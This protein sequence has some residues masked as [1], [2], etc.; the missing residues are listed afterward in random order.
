MPLPQLEAL[1]QFVLRKV[2]QQLAAQTGA[3]AAF[4][5]HSD[6]ISALIKVAC[7]SMENAFEHAYW[8]SSTAEPHSP[9]QPAAR[10]D[11][12]SPVRAAEASEEDPDIDDAELARRMQDEEHRQHLL[13]M[14]GIG[15]GP[16]P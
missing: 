4:W 15:E 11:V 13:Q 12:E 5:I 9:S 10:D 7:R 14:A 3:S 8:Q 2:L 16:P 6:T 1:S